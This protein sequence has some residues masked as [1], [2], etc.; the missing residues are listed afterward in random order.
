MV[1]IALLAL[2]LCVAGA[3]I[4]LV[5]GDDSAVQPTSVMA[6]PGPV[7]YE[8]D[9]DLT[10]GWSTFDGDGTA[11]DYADGEYRLTINRA[12]YMVWGN[13]ELPLDLADLL[14]D[15]SLLAEVEAT[16]VQLLEGYPGHVAPLIRRWLGDA[17]QYGEV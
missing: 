2:C 13:P 11:V 8:E 10:G 4:W 17:V 6:E 14:R 15:E 16:A 7:L 12:E 3:V 5:A 9:F 1:G